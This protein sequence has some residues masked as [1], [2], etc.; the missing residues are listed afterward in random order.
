MNTIPLHNRDAEGFTIVEVV[1]TLVIVALFL[2]GFFQSFLLLESQR[3]NVARQAK[4][5]D[6]AYSNLRK[7]TT[8]PAGLTCDTAGVILGSTTQSGASSAYGFNAEATDGLGSDP[9]QE[10]RAFP[11]NG[12]DP[13]NF[14]AS[15][16]KIESTVI[17]GISRE[18]VTHASYVQ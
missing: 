1:I 4:A 15:P 11:T 12:C 3:V 10:V 5:S 14:A 6:I 9:Q 13:A 7:F 16:V 2:T 17:F 8:R 18:K